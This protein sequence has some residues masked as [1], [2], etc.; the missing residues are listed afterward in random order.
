MTSTRI[1]MSRKTSVFLFGHSFPARLLRQSRERRIDP[2]TLVGLSNRFTLFVEGHPG[3]TYSRIFD[4]LSHYLALLKSRTIDILLVD[5]GSN[6]LC[7]PGCPPEV[8]L[9]NVDRF[10]DHLESH[11]VTPQKIVF[12]SVIRRTVISRSGQVSCTTFNHRAKK[13]NRLLTN[14]LKECPGVEIYVQRRIDYPKYLGDGCHLN[15]TGMVKYFWGIK[16]AV[17][18]CKP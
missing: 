18:R 10:L 3:L 9:Q 12:L 6:D 11:G 16:E 1:G 13:F 2:K 17:Y 15:P 8:V 4:N 7:D 5:L 14:K